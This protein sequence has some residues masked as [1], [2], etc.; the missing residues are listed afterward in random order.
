MSFPLRDLSKDDT[1]WIWICFRI[2][3]TQRD[4]IIVGRTPHKILLG[5]SL[6]GAAKQLLHVVCAQRY[7]VTLVLP[8]ECP[9]GQEHDPLP[10]GL[11]NLV[12]M[13]RYGW[14]FFVRLLS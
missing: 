12:I 13:G 4:W 9:R 14:F 6:I 7:D 8:L 2:V 10:R 11:I 5:I 3:S 1:S